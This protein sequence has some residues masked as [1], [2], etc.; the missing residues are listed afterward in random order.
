[1]IT[2]NTIKMKLIM[3]VELVSHSILI[4]KFLSRKEGKRN[5]REEG[6]RVRSKEDIRVREQRI[7]RLMLS[8]YLSLDY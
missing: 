1:M 4:R 8:H 5:T 7:K 3:N 6:I 2:L